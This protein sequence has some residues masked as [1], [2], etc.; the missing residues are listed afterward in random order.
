[1]RGRSANPPGSESMAPLNRW[2]PLR[3]DHRLI[4]A[5]P[6]GVE[7]NERRAMDEPE[8]IDETDGDELYWAERE[9]DPAFIAS[10]IKAREQIAQ[11]KTISHEELKKRL[12]IE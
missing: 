5:T 9:R 6:T 11:G 4:S 2:S 12:G 8:R 10:L 3:Y 1:M 7:K